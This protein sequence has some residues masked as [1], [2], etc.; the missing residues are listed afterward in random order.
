MTMLGDGQDSVAAVARSENGDSLDVFVYATPSSTRDDPRTQFF[1]MAGQAHQALLDQGLDPGNVVS[2]WIRF[3]SAPSWSWREAL[4]EVWQI[5]GVLPVTALVQPP[6]EPSCAC[7]LALHAIKTDKGSGVWLSPTAPVATTVLHAGARH[8]RLMS[9]MPRPELG[10][11]ASIVDLTYDMLAQA[12]HALTA[13]G[14]SFADIVRIWIYVRD[15]KR[16]NQ[17]VNRTSDRYFTDQQLARR[18]LATCV[19]GIPVGADSPIAMDAYAVAEASGARIEETSPEALPGPTGEA[20]KHEAIFARTAHLTEPG[21]RWIWV[22]GSA[23]SDLLEPL[24][25]VG[26]VQ[27]Q[28]D[29]TF[30]RVASL[31]AE[32]NMGLADVLAATAYLKRA[33]HLD[34][35]RRAAFAHGLRATVPCEVVVADGGDP[36]RLCEVELCAARSDGPVGSIQDRNSRI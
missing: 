31:L 1:S 5:S 10:R 9:V 34:D 26:D 15:I 19:E 33:D 30:D 24:L 36:E 21:R 20:P 25:S 8:V 7:S 13:R 27:G 35:F 17:P 14:M 28:L 32:A 23:T 16:S 11:G 4:A 29:R 2:A 6:A 18:P 22:S 12:G 3:A